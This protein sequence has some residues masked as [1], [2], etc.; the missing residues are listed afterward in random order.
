MAVVAVLHDGPAQEA[1]AGGI[2]GAVQGVGEAVHALGHAGADGHAQH[3]LSQLVDPVEAGGAAG[4]DEA[5]GDHL[6]EAGALG[7]D[8]D[9][10]Q[11]LLHAGLEDLGEA[12]AGDLLVALAAESLQFHRL[13]RVDAGGQG[14]AALRLEVFHSGEGG[15][16]A[17]HQVVRQVVAAHREHRSVEYGAVHEYGEAG[18]AAA[19]VGDDDALALLLLLQHGFRC[20][21]GR[22]DQGLHLDAG[23]LHALGEVLDGC[24]GA[25][26]DVGLHVQAL[27]VHPDGVADVL[28]AVDDEEAGDNVEHLAVGGEV[29]GLGLLDGAVDVLV[30]DRAL[31]AGDGGDAAV[32]EGVDVVAADAD[33]GGQHA[34][35]A[36][37]L[38]LFHGVGDGFGGL[39]DVIHHS[40][41]DSLSWGHT[42]A[43]DT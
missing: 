34:A 26:D 39:L 25:G 8:V 2:G 12:A 14:G 13:L 43:E 19:D 23:A 1:H 16:Q 4:E 40:L 28:L 35:A 7:I 31:A 21:Q 11:D 18:G 22:E 33:V 24:D 38:R 29:E 17:G 10:L 32:I 41:L 27:A 42:D 9:H 3:L 30:G 5:G 36:G 37:A 6:V 20:S 15:A